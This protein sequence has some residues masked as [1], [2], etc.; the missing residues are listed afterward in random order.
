MGMV[1]D[2]GNLLTQLVPQAQLR[3]LLMQ[4]SVKKWSVDSL[5]TGFYNKP[6]SALILLIE[7]CLYIV[8]S[9]AA[10]GCSF[11]NWSTRDAAPLTPVAHGNRA[12]N[13]PQMVVSQNSEI[14]KLMRPMTI[15]KYYNTFMN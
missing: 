12:P 8:V 15:G 14:A 1:K 2:T 6:T 9:D 10:T 7:N 13:L 4:I 3:L 5:L 11:R